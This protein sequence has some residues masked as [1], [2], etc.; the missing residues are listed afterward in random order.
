MAWSTRTRRA[1]ALVGLFGCLALAWWT[2]QQRLQTAPVIWLLTHVETSEQGRTLGLRHLTE[3]SWQISKS[4]DSHEIGWET[5]LW[6]QPGQ[7]PEATAQ[8]ELQLPHGVQTVQVT[9][10]FAPGP[11]MPTVQTRGQLRV[12]ASTDD[13][14]VTIDVDRCGERIP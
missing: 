13:R 8:V 1:L 12:D 4:A 2:W 11:G 9:C 3:F 5:K 6:F 14:A 7:A 10:R